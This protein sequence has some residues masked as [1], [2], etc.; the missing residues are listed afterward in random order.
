MDYQMMLVALQ[1]SGS[2]SDVFHFDTGDKAGTFPFCLFNDI[3]NYQW[4][5]YHNV[6]SNNTNE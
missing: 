2:D 1:E 4:N 3:N 5:K 6:V